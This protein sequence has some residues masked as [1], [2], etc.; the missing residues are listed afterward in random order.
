MPGSNGK[1]VDKRDF[2]ANRPLLR[3]DGD[4]GRDRDEEE[5]RSRFSGEQSND[6]L[7]N[8]VVEEIVEQDRQRLAREVVR[9]VS[10]AW[11]VIS[12]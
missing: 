8:N 2:D 1:V 5:R 12:W 4:S 10:F 3:D 9:V 11:G 6:G 7:L